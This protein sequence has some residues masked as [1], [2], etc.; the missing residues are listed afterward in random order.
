[1]ADPVSVRKWIIE[2]YGRNKATGE[3]A[4]VFGW[5][6]PGVRRVTQQMRE[7]GDALTRFHLR[8]SKEKFTP[9]RE[10]G[11]FFK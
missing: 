11:T 9:E 5:R 2:A 10:S 4:A 6:R 8:G 7:R 3:I 1:M